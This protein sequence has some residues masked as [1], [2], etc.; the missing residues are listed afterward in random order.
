MTP[1]LTHTSESRRGERHWTT[2]RL[3]LHRW[4]EDRAPSLAEGYEGAVELL[5]APQFPGRIH[6]ICHVV[7][8]IYRLLPAAL[9]S[10]PA[11]RPAEV[12]PNL[13]FELAKAWADFPPP[14]RLPEHPT[15]SQIVTPQVFCRAERIVLRCATFSDGATFGRDLALALHRSLDPSRAGTLSPLVIN[16]FND[17][18]GYFVKRAHLATSVDSQPDVDGLVDHFEAFERSFHSFVGPY[19]S[20][21]E[22]LDAILQSTNA[23][24]D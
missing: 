6:F 22:E 3:E 13:A 4:F 15:D 14:A 9:G 2:L 10:K 18:Y 20:G 21:K 12:L 19:F 11:T 24:T 8:D 23:T 5:H 1:A 16:A 17:E 7:R